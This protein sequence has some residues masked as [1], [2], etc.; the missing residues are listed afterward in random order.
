ML[1]YLTEFDPNTQCVICGKPHNT[2]YYCAS[3]GLDHWSMHTQHSGTKWIL[4]NIL[5]PEN[6][7]KV[8]YCG[9]CWTKWPN[10]V[11]EEIHKTTGWEI[12]RF[13]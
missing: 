3:C 10:D 11:T 7:H 6:I 8:Y 9:K 13:F 1:I 4:Y 5:V 12:Q 2:K